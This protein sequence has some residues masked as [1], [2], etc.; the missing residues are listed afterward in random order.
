MS[1]REFLDGKQ[2][3]ALEH[4]LYS[5]DLNSNDFFLLPKTK[6]ILD[7]RHFDEINEE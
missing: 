6:E 2:I 7:G 4:P 3:T 1:V 5:P